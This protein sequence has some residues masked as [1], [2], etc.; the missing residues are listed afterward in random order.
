[1]KD[2]R[3]RPGALQPY[4]A[5]DIGRTAHVPGKGY[6]VNWWRRIVRRIVAWL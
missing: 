6:R 2:N 1:M 4:R 3:T 5:A